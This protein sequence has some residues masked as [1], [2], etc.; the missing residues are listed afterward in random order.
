MHVY[1][2]IATRLGPVGGL[3]ETVGC[4]EP[5]GYQLLCGTS[6]FHMFHDVGVA[7]IA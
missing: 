5:F 6:N 1:E 7:Y 2:C 3:F 4:V